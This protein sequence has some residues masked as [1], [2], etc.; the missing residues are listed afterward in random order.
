MVQWISA[1]VQKIRGNEGTEI[2]EFAVSMPLLVVMAVGIYDFGSGF[3]L[4]HE[5]NNAVREGARV[6]VSHPYPSDPRVNDGCGAPYS[7]CLVRDVVASNLR[8]S[9]GKDCD[10]GTTSG[11]HGSG[12]VWTFTGSGGCGDLVL[13]VNRGT[14]NS[15]TASLPSPP[16]DSATYRIENTKVTLAYPYQWQFNRAFKLISPSANYLTS[17]ISVS[18]TMQNLD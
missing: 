15:N 4:K 11:A 17:T 5:L 14:L 18:T 13:E 2:I 3:T 7:I 16:F 1:F 10:L 8:Q 12:Y 6:A 9:T